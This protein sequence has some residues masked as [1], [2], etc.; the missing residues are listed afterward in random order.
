LQVG[1]GYKQLAEK[2]TC[3]KAWQKQTAARPCI[4]ALQGLHEYS[5]LRAPQSSSRRIDGLWAVDDGRCEA[6]IGSDGSGNTESRIDKAVIITTASATHDLVFKERRSYQAKILLKSEYGRQKRPICRKRRHRDVGC[7][8]TGS[9]QLTVS[10]EG[11]STTYNHRSKCWLKSI[12]S[13]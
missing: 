7:R 3:R 9:E 1:F 2:S 10:P 8:I 12:W 13:F 5:R 4:Y 6:D 11:F